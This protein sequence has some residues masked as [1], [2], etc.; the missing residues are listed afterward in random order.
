M[1]GQKNMLKSLLLILFLIFCFKDEIY[2]QFFKNLNKKQLPIFSNKGDT[3]LLKVVNHIG[4]TNGYKIKIFT[5]KKDFTN[6]NVNIKTL[7]SYEIFGINL[8]SFQS[9]ISIIEEL[10]KFKSNSNSVCFKTFTYH[11]N[12]D[13][14]NSKFYTLQIDALYLINVLCFDYYSINYSPCPVLYDTTTNEEINNNQSKLKEVFKIYEEW[15]EKNKTNK[16]TNFSFPLVGT[17]FQWKYGLQKNIF[18]NHLPNWPSKN[19]SDIAYRKEPKLV[20][21]E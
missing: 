17:K 21:L 8:S 14:V 7:N 12:F 6:N 18:F 2:A 16:F 15:F 19:W 10:L 9:K 13:T 3:L 11:S 20:I 5:W 1:K 4:D